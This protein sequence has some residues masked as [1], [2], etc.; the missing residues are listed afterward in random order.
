[1]LGVASSLGC[2][3]C[4]HSME[5]PMNDHFP[6]SPTPLPEKKSSTKSTRRGK[7]GS[8]DSPSEPDPVSKPSPTAGS[9]TNVPT[10]TSAPPLPPKNGLKVTDLKDKPGCVR[11]LT[12]LQTILQ[13]LAIPVTILLSVVA[14]S[15][16]IGQ[17]KEQ[18]QSNSM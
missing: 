6:P 11:A 10:E 4:S 8:H 5:A 3:L 1:M 14:L 17:F 7:E 16:Q 13:T 15:S 18:Q 12:I 9:Q 2:V